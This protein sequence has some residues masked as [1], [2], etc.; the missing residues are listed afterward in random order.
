MLPV[1]LILFFTQCKNSLVRLIG[2]FRID[3]GA[4]HLKCSHQHI[5]KTP[6]HTSM[7]THTHIHRVTF[8]IQPPPFK[9]GAKT[10]PYFSGHR[11]SSAYCCSAKYTCTSILGWILIYV[12]HS[13]NC[14]YMAK[15]NTYF[16]HNLNQMLTSILKPSPPPQTGTGNKLLLSKDVVTLKVNQP[17][18]RPMCTHTTPYILSLLL[19]NTQLWLVS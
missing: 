1:L 15:S 13:P 6:M 4:Y 3:Q 8:L 9:D 2:D 19:C 16:K 12:I 14:S 11:T 17:S 10:R 5:H 7:R 18:R